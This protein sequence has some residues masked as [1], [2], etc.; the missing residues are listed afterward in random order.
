MQTEVRERA[1]RPGAGRDHELGAAIAFPAGC[2]VE[3]PSTF[4]DRGHRRM[5]EQGCTVLARGSLVS[6]S[7]ARCHGDAALCLEQAMHVVAELKLRPAAHDLRRV[8]LLEWDGARAHAG[9]IG[10]QG[11]GAHPGSQIKPPGL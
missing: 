7:A 8:Q 3:L 1:V 9:G 11:D 2:Y 4:A 5:V 6:R 10:F